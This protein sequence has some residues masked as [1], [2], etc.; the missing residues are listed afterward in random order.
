LLFFL[1]FC[2]FRSPLSCL[3][4]PGRPAILD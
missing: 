4:P 1:R 3:D 2:F